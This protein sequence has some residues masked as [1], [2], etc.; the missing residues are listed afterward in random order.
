MELGNSLQEMASGPLTRGAFQDFD[1]E[2]VELIRMVEAGNKIEYKSG[3][4]IHSGI[5]IELVGIG[6]ELKIRI[7][8]EDGQIVKIKPK[9]IRE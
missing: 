3:K 2:N 5:P 8:K 1:P 6:R 7:Q 4:D 9:A